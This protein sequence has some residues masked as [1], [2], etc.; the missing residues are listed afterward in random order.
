[1]FRPTFLY[2]ESSQVKHLI[3]ELDL[4]VL[5]AEMIRQASTVVSAMVKLVGNKS[6]LP[7]P[8]STTHKELS[9]DLSASIAN[10][11]AHGRWSSSRDQDVSMMPPPPPR[12]RKRPAV[13]VVS[14]DLTSLSKADH[15]VIPALDLGDSSLSADQCADIIDTCLT[16]FTP[17]VMVNNATSKR[18]RLV[19]S[20]TDS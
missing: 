7:P 20:S 8:T 18:I 14:P 1:V 11:P 9:C 19:S 3:V 6:L 10:P 17:M 4:Q 15:G 13:M 12:Q 2:T 5:L 16:E